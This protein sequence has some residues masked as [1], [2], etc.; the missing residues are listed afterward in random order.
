MNKKIISSPIHENDKQLRTKF[1]NNKIKYNKTDGTVL[2]PEEFI[3]Y[4]KEQKGKLGGGGRYITK[5]LKKYRYC[6]SH[7]VEDIAEQFNLAYQITGLNLQKCNVHISY[8]TWA[9]LKQWRAFLNCS[10]CKIVSFLVHLDWIGIAEELCEEHK[11]L[12]CPEFPKFFMECKAVISTKS[13]VYARRTR[14]LRFDY[15]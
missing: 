11:T 10:V 4:F 3:E 13:S 9:E 2:I 8:E 7:D 15:Q 1:K 5:I 12:V 6:L 14:L